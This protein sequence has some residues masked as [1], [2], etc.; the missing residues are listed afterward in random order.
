MKPG[1]VSAPMDL[2]ANRVVYQ[3]VSKDEPNPSDFDKQIKDLTQAVV[4]NKRTVAFDA[5]RSAL[6]ARLKQEG[7]LKTYPDKLKISSALG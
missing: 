2:G 3:V 4:Q 5:F 7:K 6:E 1:E